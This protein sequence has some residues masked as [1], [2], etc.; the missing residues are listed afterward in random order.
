M[1]ILMTVGVINPSGVDPSNPPPLVVDA[2]KQLSPI[3]FAVKA[4]CLAEY[5]GMEFESPTG[6]KGNF[7]A[8]GRS[9][10]RDLPRMGALALVKNGDEVLDE[11]GLGEE[12]YQGAMRHLAILSA[13]N[14]FIS[15]LGLRMQSGS[16]K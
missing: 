13:A 11:L 8:R 3:A 12:T 4:V 1:V 6:P 10:L 15:W 5:H 2:L 14:L 16:T 7:F 9:L